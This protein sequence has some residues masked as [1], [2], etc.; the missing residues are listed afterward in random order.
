MNDRQDGER[1]LT[2]G[3]NGIAGV[4]GILGLEGVEVEVA[5]YAVAG[6]AG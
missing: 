4:G 6:L 1:G 3:W 5:G 2:L